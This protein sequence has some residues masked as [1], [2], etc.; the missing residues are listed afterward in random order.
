MFIHLT[1][2]L[3]ELL[4]NPLIRN[5]TFDVRSTRYGT[6]FYLL[7]M[8]IWGHVGHDWDDLRH[9]EIVESLLRWIGFTW[10]ELRQVWGDMRHFLTSQTR[11]GQVSK[12]LGDIC[13][14]LETIELSYGAFETIWD[15]LRHIRNNM[16]HAMTSHIDRG[17]FHG[18][19]LHLRRFRT[20]RVEFESNW[21][22][23][24]RVSDDWMS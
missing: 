4:V 12:H 15:K 14:E 20:L 1:L 6:G 7:V 19:W 9:D 21:A 10:V 16:R 8:G 2:W 18:I 13:D 5:C 23:L 17:E 24:R 3:D 11:P 22:T